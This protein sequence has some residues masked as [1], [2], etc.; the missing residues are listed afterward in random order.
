[1]KNFSIYDTII[2]ALE[3]KTKMKKTIKS[4][5]LIT[6]SLIIAIS[7]TACSKKQAAIPEAD[8]SNLPVI[9]DVDFLYEIE[10]FNST[11]FNT[12]NLKVGAMHTPTA[13]VWAQSGNCYT[14]DESVATV[15]KNGNVKGISRGTAYV[16]IVGS[17]G[18][19]EVYKYI[20]E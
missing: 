9:E 7:M 13:A 8:L 5:G 18:M 19:Y 12:F 17:T 16:V 15:A 2:K 11:P 20:I 10:N 14:S 4:I 6:L 3:R 1:M